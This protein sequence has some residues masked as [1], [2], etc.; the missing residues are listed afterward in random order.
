MEELIGVSACVLDEMASHPNFGLNE[1][2]NSHVLLVVPRCIP[3][4][5]Q[6][7]MRLSTQAQQPRD[8]DFIPILETQK[9]SGYTILV[10]SRRKATSKDLSNLAHM[11][12][13]L[14]KLANGM[15]RMGKNDSGDWNSGGG[16]DSE[17]HHRFTEEFNMI[18]LF[19]QGWWSRVSARSPISLQV[20]M[21]ELIGVSACVLGEMASHPNFGLNELKPQSVKIFCYN[22]K[23]RSVM[24]ELRIW[25]LWM[26][27]IDTYP[28]PNKKQL[29]I[30]AELESDFTHVIHEK[31]VEV[32]EDQDDRILYSGYNPLSVGLDNTPAGVFTLTR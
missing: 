29:K 21:E 31:N 17:D 30:G 5:L 3:S 8:G 16:R 15:Q 27:M 6:H 14:E 18:G 19:L 22:T 9:K 10:A 4:Q 13:D 12:F 1:L 26:V 23:I 25:Q 7:L 32:S 24:T 2:T 28:Q 20:L 11:T